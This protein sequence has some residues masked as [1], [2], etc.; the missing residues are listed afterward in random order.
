MHAARFLLRLTAVLVLALPAAHAEDIDIY[1]LPNT[2]GFRPNVLIMLDNSANWS[3]SISTPICSAA[4][5]AVRNS[6]PNKE[7]GTKM[8][9]QKCAL[10]RLIASMTWQELGQFNFALMMFNE[11]PDAGGYPRKAFFHVTDAA[12]RQAMLD[13]IS[14][15]GINRDKTN[16]AS[17][18]ESFYEAYQWFMGSTV[19][20]GNKTATKHDSA[21]FT[22]GTKT[23]YLTPG[24]GC[25]KNHI[26]YLANGRPADN[27]NDALVL[28][29]RLNS[30][31][32]RTR[33][34]VA[35]SV[36]NSDEAN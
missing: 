2:E 19:H 11:S 14:G 34:P 28:L 24:V 27:D 1:S 17:T 7:E 36:S 9:A 22:D 18:G 4:G 5:A 8:G 35:E 29:R 31:A 6:N 13:V 21:A 26:I 12:G 15:L 16:N 23:R 32:A 30:S 20:K 3:A 10:Y 25:A 33:I